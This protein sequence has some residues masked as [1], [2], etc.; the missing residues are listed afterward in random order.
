MDITKGTVLFQEQ[1]FVANASSAEEFEKELIENVQKA[2]DF[3]TQMEFE[4]LSDRIHQATVMNQGWYSEDE[5]YSPAVQ[6]DLDRHFEIGMFA[7]FLLLPP[8][9]QQKWLSG[10]DAFQEISKVGVCAVGIFGLDGGLDLN[11]KIGKSTGYDDESKSYLVEVPGHDD[12]VAIKR[13]NLKTPGGVFRCNAF[14]I[15]L[16]SLRAR[17]NHA[18][19]NNMDA[20]IITNTQGGQECELRTNRDISQGEELTGCYLNWSEASTEY[21]RK[22]LSAKYGFLCQCTACQ[23]DEIVTNV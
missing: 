8:E 9:L 7:K 16:L 4:D 22:A 17:L 3:A 14:P 12:L 19:N 5:K 11:G 2:C 21:R 20:K 23:N 10:H 13:E 1:P 15:G 6:K 18:C